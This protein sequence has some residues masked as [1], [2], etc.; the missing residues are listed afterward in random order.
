M[1]Y[2]NHPCFS[3]DAR[4]TTA[5]IHLAVAPKCNV[6]CNF[7]NRKYDC[8]NESRP[9]VTTSLL[10][11]QEALEHLRNADS[12]VKNLAVVGIAGPGD[13][14]A[15]AQETLETMRLVKANFPEKLLCVS[16]NGLNIAEY[17]P[18]LADLNVSHVTITV[19]AVEARVGAQMYD[20]FYFNRKSYFGIEGAQLLLDRQTEAIRK[21]KECNITVKIN[22]VV[23]PRVNEH[24]VGDIAK[25]T[26][27]L[28]ADL[29]N[30]IPLIPV[31]GTPFA[32]LYEPSAADM[33]RVR[34][35]TSLYI[36]QMTHCSRCRADAVGLLGHDVGADLQFVPLFDTRPY[37]AVATAD[38]VSV[39][40]HLG[41]AHSLWIYENKDGKTQ[42][43]ETRSIAAQQNSPDRWN[44][45]ADVIP[46]CSALLVSALGQ[47]PLRDLRSRGLYVEAV[48]GDVETVVANLFN[49]KDIPKE[50]LRFAGHC[51]E[52]GECR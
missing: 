11:P 38:G 40:Q 52:G 3:A 14:F 16:S 25:Y 20:W 26:A 49:N 47:S 12:R 39:N 46:D 48:E 33:R 35:K 7:C 50:N 29:Q 17:I 43:K 34:A 31:D 32:A 37:I 23:V 36:E 15:N 6:Q 45:I 30:C 42:L 41:R 24:H 28:G 19:N 1:K 18:E 21:L 2:D 44:A 4:H 22:T 51:S 8:A 27:A 10:S 5:R 13:P 9:G